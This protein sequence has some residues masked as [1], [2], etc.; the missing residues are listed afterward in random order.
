MRRRRKE[1]VAQKSLLPVKDEKRRRR[2]ESQLLQ[3]VCSSDTLA[4]PFGY[5]G[6][7]GGE[8]EKGGGFFT[9]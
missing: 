3:S 5:V 4:C 8:K 1:A 7:Y 2:G 6:R 9:M